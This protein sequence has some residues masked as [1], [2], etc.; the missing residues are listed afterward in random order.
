MKL[1]IFAFMVA[2][3][4]SLVGCTKTLRTYQG[5]ERPQDQLAILEGRLTTFT[6]VDGKSIC[7]GFIACDDP[8][9]IITRVALLPGK[10]TISYGYHLIKTG[11]RGGTG[12]IDMKAG[13]VY[14]IKE[15]TCILW[16]GFVAS[17][18]LTRGSPY[19]G[20]MW[21]EDQ[22]TGEVVLGSRRLY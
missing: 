16:C 21:I 13:H 10:H 14:V 2:I 9:R 15:D 17:L 22:A 4:I 11:F 8:Y 18:S 6:S 5:P 19:K 1:G 7:I 20:A 12:V 3:A